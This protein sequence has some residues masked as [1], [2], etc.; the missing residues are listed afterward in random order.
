MRPGCV[1]FRSIR[2]AMPPPVVTDHTARTVLRALLRQPPNVSLEV[3]LR[4]M[5]VD[6]SGG[7]TATIVI[8]TG[9]RG[10]FALRVAFLSLSPTECTGSS[11]PEAP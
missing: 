6:A 2:Q 4:D 5:R 8:E 3:V 1:R 11:E 9:D 7:V 10:A